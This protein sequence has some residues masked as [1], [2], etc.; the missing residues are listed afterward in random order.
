[1]EHVKKVYNLLCRGHDEYY[2]ELTDI[3]PSQ[4]AFS[5]IDLSLFYEIHL[6]QIINQISKV[7]GQNRVRKE[8]YDKIFLRMSI[9][10]AIRKI[11][12]SLRN[13]GC[14]ICFLIA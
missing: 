3:M 2:Y 10:F 8:P 11:N 14:K 13:N 7:M 6:K 12:F 5:H 9:L 4:I 1:M